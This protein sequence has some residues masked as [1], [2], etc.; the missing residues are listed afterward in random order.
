MSDTENAHLHAAA[1]YAA[2]EKNL[3]ETAPAANPGTY[4]Y[5]VKFVCGLQNQAIANP[6]SAALSR[7]IYSTEINIFNFNNVPANLLKS[8]V[9][10]VVNNQVIAREPANTGIIQNEQLQLPPNRATM[11]DCCK[12]STLPGGANNLLKI[13]W[14]KIMS[15]IELAVTALYTVADATTNNVQSIDVEEVSA[16]MI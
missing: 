11:D 14:L 4:I 9:F 5:N 3:A 15:N 12:F 7:G 13:G 8:F 10:V 2:A 6:C 1:E 16:K